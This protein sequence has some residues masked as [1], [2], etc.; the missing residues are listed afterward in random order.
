MCCKNKHPIKQEEANVKEIQFILLL[1]AGGGVYC[2]EAHD[3]G[4]E[5]T[6]VVV[7]AVMT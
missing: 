4:A 7:G 6:C 2:R 1:F 5:H 3:K